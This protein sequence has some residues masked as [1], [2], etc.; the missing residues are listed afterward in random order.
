MKKIFLFALF[1]A[2]PFFINF[3]FSQPPPPPPQD[4]PLD[5]GLT[6]L[7]AAGLVYGARQLHKQQKD[8]S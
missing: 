6:L 1:L 7:V 4:I 3:V 8:K 5:G 2:A